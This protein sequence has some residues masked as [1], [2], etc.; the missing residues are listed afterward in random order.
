MSQLREAFDDVL[1]IKGLLPEN[2][3]YFVSLGA[4]LLSEKK[5]ALIK[6]SN[7]LQ[8]IEITKTLHISH[9]YLNQKKNIKSLLIDIT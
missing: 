7:Q 6:L 1:K 5:L 8:H 4:A 3:L 9:L 2:S